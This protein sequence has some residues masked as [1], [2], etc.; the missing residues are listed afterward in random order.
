MNS[1]STTHRT[2]RPRRTLTALA[3]SGL[4][5]AA[6]GAAAMSATA[7]PP[8]GPGGIATRPNP[9]VLIKTCGYDGS[10]EKEHC[11]TWAEGMVNLGWKCVNTFDAYTCHKELD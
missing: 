1:G 4:M 6:S 3:V 11:K 10:K 7:D 5:V 2:T 9:S 8:R